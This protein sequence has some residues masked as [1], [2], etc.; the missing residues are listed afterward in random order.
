[1]QQ[2]TDRAEGGSRGAAVMQ[3]VN[4]AG[5]LQTGTV[6]AVHAVLFL[7]GSHMRFAQPL[8]LQPNCQT[9]STAQ[10]ISALLVLLAV[11]KLLWSGHLRRVN[12][13]QA[14]CAASGIL[15]VLPGHG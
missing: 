1:M 15:D 3:H 11:A 12:Q 7:A 6:P 4:A 9:Q 2:G 5:K 14:S 8:L 10:N 13:G